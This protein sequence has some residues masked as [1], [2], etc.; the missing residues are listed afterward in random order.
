MLTEADKALRANAIGASDI[1]AIVGMDPHRKPID[2]WLDKMGRSTYVETPEQ[3]M[4]HLM[5]PAIATMYE[6]RMNAQLVDDCKTVAHPELPWAVA[7]PDRR[8]IVGPAPYVE[9]KNVGF[10]MH[11][12]WGKEP[13]GAPLAKVLQVMWQM[14]VLGAANPDVEA[15]RIDIAALLTGTTSRIYPTLRDDELIGILREAAEKFFVDCIVSRQP[16]PLTGA[17]ANRLADLDYEGNDGTILQPNNEALA[18]LARLKRI[19]K[20]LDKVKNLNEQA[21]ADA[22]RL[23]GNADGIEGCFTW[24]LR[25]GTVSWAKVAHEVGVTP[26]IVEKH[27]GA[28]TRVFALT[29]RRK[30]S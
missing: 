18:V 7:T 12:A 1:A 11:F 19:R 4:G 27:R 9:I 8:A 30:K 21:E 28:P 23:I 2:V 13:D 26:D 25:A 20:A 10:G 29:E 16:P 6:R 3:M 15:N 22:K 5:E 17:E 24:K 14:F